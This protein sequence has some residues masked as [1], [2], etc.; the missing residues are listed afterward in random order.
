MKLYL[1]DDSSSISIYDT[2]RWVVFSFFFEISDLRLSAEWPVNSG[3]ARIFF[4]KI[5][6]PLPPYWAVTA[7]LYGNR[8]S[9]HQLYRAGSNPAGP[10][11]RLLYYFTLLPR[12][13]RGNGKTISKKCLM[14]QNLQAILPSWVQAFRRKK[15]EGTIHPNDEYF[16]AH[17][18]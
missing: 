8:T 9:L 3:T 4:E 1:H 14:Y 17:L 10:G 12:Y 11:V 2:V 13:A 16:I 15:N 18:E 7:F 6:F 5:V